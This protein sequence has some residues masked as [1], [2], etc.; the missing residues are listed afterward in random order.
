MAYSGLRESIFNA[1]QNET[2]RRVILLCGS[3]G[4]TRA[5][6]YTASVLRGLYTHHALDKV[7]ALSGVSGGSAA[8]AYY[9]IHRDELMR[10]DASAEIA[11]RKYFNTMAAPFIDDVLE[12]MS[13]LRTCGGTRT[14]I[15]LRDSFIKRMESAQPGA[16]RTVGQSP[17][18]L[19]FNTTR[20][21]EQEW[22]SGNL[23]TATS[24][25][26]GAP[27]IFSNIDPASF[28][29]CGHREA[30]SLC[31]SS[32]S[33]CDPDVPL[34]AAAALSANFPP[35]FANAA[36][37][38]ASGAN[39]TRYWVTDGGASENRGIISLL[40]A[41]RYALS[42]ELAEQFVSA[43][44]KPRALPEIHIIV[45][46]AS[47]EDTSFVQDRGLNSALCAA[48]NYANQLS[49]E[50]TAQINELCRELHSKAGAK[51]KDC[52]VHFHYL[53]MPDV[54]RV[55]GSVGTHWM[56]AGTYA[57][58]HKE[59][60]GA[61]GDHTVL[62]GRSVEALIADLHVDGNPTPSTRDKSEQVEQQ[63]VRGWIRAD[64]YDAAWEKTIEDINRAE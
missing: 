22:A 37:D 54:L 4:G 12:G 1:A 56:L 2:P 5:A 8:I 35:V 17:V 57:L 32:R 46:D 62:R 41:L 47:A 9:S 59:K 63:K 49:L 7:V 13:E 50:L 39:R 60:N 16:I 55:T 52:S 58:H 20:A 25:G 45:A 28:E 18:G 36:V 21:G 26:A 40:Y 19:I 15:L 38:V 10:G 33:I 42:Q 24:A 34:T 61:A 27:L 43:D 29:H 3:G 23:A 6:L 64:G 30:P 14:G 44:P 48:D 53:G 11:W 51:S 31:L